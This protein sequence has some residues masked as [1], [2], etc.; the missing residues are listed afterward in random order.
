MRD[1]VIYIRYPAAVDA[2]G[3]PIEEDVVLSV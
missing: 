2:I 3:M 1:E